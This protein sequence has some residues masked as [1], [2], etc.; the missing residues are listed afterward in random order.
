MSLQNL[1]HLFTA[2]LL[3]CGLAG[4]IA[5]AA[6]VIRPTSD[7]EVVEVL[8]AVAR[9]RPQ[10]QANKGALLQTSLA[11]AQAAREAIGVARQTGD[12]RY[13]GRAQ[14]SLGPWWDKPDA[15]TELAIL[16][17]TVQQGRHEFEPARKILTRVLVRDPGNAQ[18][19]LNLAALE[20]LT[21]RYPEA[22][23]A[24]DAVQKAGQSLYA[25]A[26][27]LE[28]R[29]L[30]GQHARAR[31]GFKTLLAEFKQSDQRSWVY[32][33][34]AESEERAGKDT[35][36]LDAYRNSLRLGP[37]LYTSIAYSDVLLRMGSPAQALRVL[38]PL[39][40]TDAVLLRQATALRRMGDAGWQALRTS[41][42]ERQSAL[43]RRGDDSRLHG[44]EQALVAL[45]LD[46]DAVQAL[47]LATTNLTLQ[48][49]PL[50]WWIALRSASHSQNSS[51]V[52]ALRQQVQ[53]MGLVDARLSDGLK[54][55]APK[56]NRL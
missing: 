5:Y 38:Q 6:D 1:H 36:A 34:L 55:A 41:L 2:A 43:D 48:R 45:W 35:A 30:Q 23:Q 10:A 52:Q 24:C 56:A 40:L 28:T 44:R 27:E 29:S 15:P 12:T 18:G 32:S 19:W 26:C 53:A 4:S 22:L 31:S 7:D 33:L 50:D 37:D 47:T 13:W 25:T 8:P 20:R 21:G 49:E 11:A 54:A 39:P 46:D 9:Q 17:S 42:R 3:C 51:Q 14:A 16:Q